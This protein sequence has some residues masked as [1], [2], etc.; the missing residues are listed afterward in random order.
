[1]N[2]NVF[3]SDTMQSSPSHRVFLSATVLAVAAFLLTTSTYTHPPAVAFF[4]FVQVTGIVSAGAG[5][6]YQTASFAVGGFVRSTSS[7]VKV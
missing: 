6:F 5:A 3:V 2:G 7:R 1:M 4:I